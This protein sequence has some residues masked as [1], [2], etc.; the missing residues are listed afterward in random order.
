MHALIFKYNDISLFDKRI[1]Y[2]ECWVDSDPFHY[3]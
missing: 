1:W 3:N 2:V